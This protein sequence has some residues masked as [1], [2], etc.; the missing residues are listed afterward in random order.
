MKFYSSD[1]YQECDGLVNELRAYNNT[2]MLIKY[3]YLR[4]KRLTKLICENVDEYKFS[5]FSPDIYRGFVIYFL[6]SV[7][8]VFIEFSRR[9]TRFNEFW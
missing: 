3:A 2:V 9:L 4:N 6:R 8:M 7:R 5:T 1:I